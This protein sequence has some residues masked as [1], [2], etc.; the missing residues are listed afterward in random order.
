[1]LYDITYT[2]RLQTC[3]ACYCTK[4]HMIKSSTGENVATKRHSKHEMYEA[5]ADV[6]WQTV[7]H[8]TMFL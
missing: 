1:M 3:T 6:T 2:P 7:L 5:T 4:Q 8:Q